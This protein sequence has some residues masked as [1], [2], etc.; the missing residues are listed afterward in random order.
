MFTHFSIDFI[1]LM[2]LADEC[3]GFGPGKGG[4]F[5]V[6]VERR[7][8]PSADSIE[9]LFALAVCERIFGVHVKAVGAYVEF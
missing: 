7:F 5:A 4:A 9:A 2:V 6:G 8:V 1:C 3:H